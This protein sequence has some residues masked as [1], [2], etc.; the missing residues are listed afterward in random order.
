MI[1]ERSLGR[2][3]KK[4]R[5][6]HRLGV[7]GRLIRSPYAL[8]AIAENVQAGDRCNATTRNQRNVD[9]TDPA[10]SHSVRVRPGD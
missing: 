2:L 8:F 4:K 7:L 5:G 1:A 10:P 6:I 9:L 3:D